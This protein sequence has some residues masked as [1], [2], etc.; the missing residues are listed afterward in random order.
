MCNLYLIVGVENPTDYKVIWTD[1][2]PKVTGRQG[3][4]NVL[5]TPGP[6]LRDVKVAKVMETYSRHLGHSSG[7]SR[8]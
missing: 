4:E 5:T 7:T 1:I 2:K 6:Q 8:S 3:H